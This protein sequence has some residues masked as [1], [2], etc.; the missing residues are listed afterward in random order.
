MK[1]ASK[2]TNF[3]KELGNLCFF[4]FFG[5]VFFFIHR[6][7][8]VLLYKNQLGPNADTV[9]FLQAFF[10][11]FRFDA[12]AICYFLI[13]PFL[14]LLLLSPFGKFNI[15][16]KTRI[17]CQYIF[18]V[19]STLI[20][21]VTYNYFREYNDQF[22]NFLFLGLYD[23]QK[24]VANTIIEY[25]HPVLNTFVI[26]S[27]IFIAIFILRKF[28]KKERIYKFL[29]RFQTK[30][31]RIL[32]VVL[33]VFCFVSSIRGSFTK[34]P[35]IKKWSAVA[36]D[37]FL[38]KTILNPY[39]A[40]LSAKH[41]FDELN[42]ID[43]K[44]PFIEK[45]KGDIT[46]LYP[47]QKLV[48]AIIEKEAKGDTI[49][50]PKQ[51]FLVVM[52]SYDSWPLMDKYAPFGFSKNLK[53]IGDK[54]MRY[55]NFLPSGHATLFSFGA[56]ITGVPY[57]G[58]N[59]SYLGSL[60]EAY[61]SSIFKQFKKLGYETN[62]FYGGFLSWEHVGEFVPYQGADHIF[63]GADMGGKSD[64]GEWGVEDEKLFD[65][66]LQKV[67]PNKYT[68]NII[69]TSSYHPPYAIDIYKKGFPY[70]SLADF[71]KEVQKYY[72]NGMNMQELGHLWY[73]DKAIGDFMTKAEKK[74]DT[75]IFGFTG[76]HYGRRFITPSP[77]LYERSSV[78][79]ILY[80][81]NI[82]VTR[83]KTPGSHIDIIPT[84]IEM[85]APKGFKYY[86]FGSDLRDPNKRNG[87]G[88]TK[89]IDRNILE[90]FAKDEQPEIIDLHTF[91]E[92][93]E[94]TTKYKAEH[95]KLM[96]LAWHYT[97]RGDTLVKSHVESEKSKVKK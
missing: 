37:N 14:T 21:V 32:L 6:L 9:D 43:G 52:E 80:G 36:K 92:E 28:E 44:N 8:F 47:G 91:K 2:W 27:T 19:F 86:S 49:P 61:K 84:L 94:K 96:A 75:G 33:T 63:S 68:L 54:G 22:N 4:W 20:C 30:P 71:P 64:S 16:R 69:L 35:A 12:T 29:Q 23:D 60:H 70:K 58:V 55:D 74:F 83:S 38:N 17:V 90:H 87:I 5:I 65:L 79:F 40:L 41:E 24:A 97:M 13:L 66:V 34:V 95:D 7:V 57:T 81:K 50:K 89:A 26:L 85:I 67:D 76:D 73:G 82:P 25:F 56:I 11:G 62:F 10:M 77:D 59:I 46:N 88:L 45:S 51:I 31:L 42:Y 3:I 72:K 18:I 1:Q 15:I 48:S 39:R 93:K 78:P 53:A